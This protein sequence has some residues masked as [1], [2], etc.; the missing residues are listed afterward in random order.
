MSCLIQ[1]VT[2]CFFVIICEMY[3]AISELIEFFQCNQCRID[4]KFF[5][6]NEIAIKNKVK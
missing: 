1:C 3:K 6:L 4:A 2:C 5:F